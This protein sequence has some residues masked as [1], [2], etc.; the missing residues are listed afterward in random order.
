MSST[1]S[2]S[3]G[4]HL[5][6]PNFLLTQIRESKAV[7]VLGAGSTIG[8]TTPDGSP[9]IP[10]APALAAAISNRFLGGA[11]VDQTL[12]TVSEYAISE[13]SLSEV[14]DY[15]KEHFE[16]LEPNDFHLSLP[17]F[18]WHGLATT[19][20]DRV[21]E[22]AYE[23]C[24]KPLQRLNPVI[25]DG[26]GFETCNKDPRCLLFLKLHGCVSRTAAPECPLIL[27]PEQYLTHRHGRCRLF[28]LLEEWAY[29]RPLIFVGHSINDLDIRD[30]LHRLSQLGANRSRYYT[31]VPDAD[32]IVQR[33]WETKKISLLTGTFENFLHTLDASIPSH[34]RPLAG[35][36]PPPL[37][38]LPLSERFSTKDVVPSEQCLQFLANDVEYV[39]SIV[40]T[41]RVSP[42]AFYRGEDPGW[43][44]IEQ[45]LDVRRALVDNILT[46][47]FLRDADGRQPLDIVLVKGHAGSGKSVL[48]RRLAW[49]AAHEFDL[50]CLYL[51][52]E[53]RIDQAA[54]LE[55]LELLSQ[56]LFLFIDNAVRHARDLVPLIRQL[57][58]A[59]Q[60]VTIL[61]GE[62]VNQWNVY[63]EVLTSFLTKEYL[64][65]YLE[66]REID[67]LLSLLQQHRALG[68]LQG[69]TETERKAAFEGRAGRQ[70]LVALHEATLGRPFEEIIADEFHNIVPAAAQDLYLTICLLN[71]LQ[72]GVRAGLI[73]RVH[74]IPFHYFE[75]HFFRPLEHVVNTTYV[76]RLR[77]HVYAA[78]HPYIAEMV[79]RQIL[80]KPE[81]RLEKYLRTIVHLNLDYS[82]DERAF[83]Q[84]FRGR[85]LRELFPDRSMVDRLFEIG[86]QLA[87]E[88]AF[89][90]HQMALYEMRVLDGDL[91]AASQ[92]LYA[93][94]RI[95][96]HDLTL[97]HSQAELQLALAEK[98]HNSLER[99]ERLRE[100]ARI[101]RDLRTARR[102]ADTPHAY[103]TLAKIALKKL[104]W[105]LASGSNDATEPQPDVVGAIREVEES[106]ADGLQRFPGEPYLLDTEARLADFLKDAP[107]AL[108]AMRNAFESDSMNSYVAMRLARS[109][110]D[111]GTIGDARTVL[112]TAIEAAP[113]NVRLHY[114]LARL[115]MKHCVDERTL[116]R[117]HLQ[118][119][120]VQG[121]SNY[122]AQRLYAR[123]LFLSGQ[124]EE[125]DGIFRTLKSASLT[126]E[127]RNDVAHKTAEE[128]SGT[129][130]RVEAT[131]C[132]LQ[133]DG[134][135][136]RVF[137]HRRNI[138]NVVFRVLGVGSRVTFRLGFTFSG[139]VA[140]DIQVLGMDAA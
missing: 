108:T 88:D 15:I 76:G 100:S 114:R 5:D 112:N 128:F 66:S 136:D 19:N 13:A 30:L 44:P 109:L 43:A 61:L 31:V 65:E 71:R 64:V 47:V 135:G 59:N 139:V 95:A 132:F 122:E 18:R 12:T 23:R 130:R 115:L 9:A 56:R 86:Q 140:V 80:K 94:S 113:T 38:N 103:H 32:P 90:L 105:R 87:K 125:A 34:F 83:R 20:F 91:S 50:T 53:G 16:P 33:F 104:E 75:T 52:S 62:R 27:T 29:E 6:I 96:P 93:A 67:A 85:V 111:A 107:R 117:Y 63:G 81:E 26:D 82:T 102:S 21:I 126:F 70:L 74:D 73:S 77:D 68:T 41:K 131:Y 69:L 54:V 84:L 2:S 10:S 11:F 45:S 89:L 7:L 3:R 36:A 24:A 92:R 72:V 106:L 37:P 120:F 55:L 138:D 39:N 79:F 35:I 134:K 48:L 14:Q 28:S 22:K 119:S 1:P 133:R 78:R 58:A 129:V 46:D 98:A 99:E 51:R 60:P 17:T 49:D 97:K 25:Q 127:R 101:A 4:R 110:E 124:E 42:D 121:D 8:S 116:I 40:S 118:K 123:E 57:K 137:A